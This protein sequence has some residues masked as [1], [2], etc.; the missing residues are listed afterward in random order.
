MTT[1]NA[2]PIFSL[3]QFFWKT[4]LFMP[5]C[6]GV[7][8]LTATVWTWPIAWVANAI[9]QILFPT[10]IA[11]VEHVGTTL[12][13]VTCLGDLAQYATN[14]TMAA[15][16]FTL[17]PLLYAYSLALYSARL[18]ASRRRIL[19]AW[20]I[21]IS[22][23]MAAI[24]FGVCFDVLKNI[25]FDLAPPGMSYP[26]GFSSWQLNLIGVGYQLG[27]LV[28]PAITPLILWVNANK[29]FFKRFFD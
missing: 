5:I 29:T 28:L 11:G 13:I 19:S 20:L 8:Y 4:L 15:L 12:D 10:L 9:L 7:W 22:I 14:K 26:T 2:P 18:L 25:A 3:S 24:V 6:F 27:Y 23:L 17:N 1:S 16:V 21:D